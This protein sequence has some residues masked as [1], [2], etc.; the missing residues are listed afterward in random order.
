M[1]DREG[2][3]VLSM[4]RIGLVSDTHGLMRPAV[5]DYLAD[6][7]HIIHAG[8]IGDAGILDALTALAP[9]TVVRGNN[10]HGAWAERLPERVDVVLA[11]TAIHVIHDI[12]DLTPKAAAEARVVVCGH[13]HKRRVDAMDGYLLV[14]PGSAGRRRFKLPIAAGMLTLASE[15]VDVEIKHFD[16]A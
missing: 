13:S 11:G 14:N 8:D 12:A 9:L 7:D 1:P 2:Q 10:D 6:A 15:H 4:M 16:P 3:T 5:L